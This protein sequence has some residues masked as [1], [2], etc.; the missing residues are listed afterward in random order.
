MMS[1]GG[2]G[3]HDLEGSRFATWQLCS[4]AAGGS[5]ERLL[6]P[7]SPIASL[8]EIFV[9]LVPFLPRHYGMSKPPSANPKVRIGVLGSG[10]MGSVHA[11]CYQRIKGA[12]VIGIFSR[13]RTVRKPP[14][15]SVTQRRS[16]MY[17]VS[18]FCLRKAVSSSRP[19][20]KERVR[21][22]T[23]FNF[24]LTTTPKH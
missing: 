19:C 10:W 5:R 2:T 21:R 14:Q 7:P 18:E 3:A 24:T 11:E 17:P 12:E 13:N 9:L 8:P 16:P 15:K 22:K 4:A 20:S 6:V 23:G 1:N